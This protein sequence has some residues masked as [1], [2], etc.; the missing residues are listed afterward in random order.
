M[1]Y[2]ANRSFIKILLERKWNKHYWRP[3]PKLVSW[4]AAPQ[5]IIST[6]E[7][8]AASSPNPINMYWFFDPERCVKTEMG[9]DESYF[10]N[11]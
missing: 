6:A 7:A 5:L 8:G 9:M 4:A 3:R 1:Q 11:I 10:N 2:T